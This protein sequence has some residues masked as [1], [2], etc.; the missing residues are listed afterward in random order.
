MLMGRFSQ[1]RIRPLS[2]FGAV[3]LLAA[4]ILLDDHV[5]N[6]VDAFVGGEALLATRC[7]GG[8]GEWN[9]PPGFLANR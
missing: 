2:T 7:T 1:A 8:G 9:R 6:F 5:R 4:A 3:E